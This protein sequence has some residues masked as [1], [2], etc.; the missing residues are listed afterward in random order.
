MVGGSSPLGHLICELRCT[1]KD[2]TDRLR[3][4]I[5]AT[6]NHR[7]RSQATHFKSSGLINSLSAYD[8]LNRRQS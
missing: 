5:A 4:A 2:T 6:H 8:N 1:V 7:R 3:A